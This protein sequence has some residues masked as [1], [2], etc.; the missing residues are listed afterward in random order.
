MA[1]ISLRALSA[2][3]RGNHAPVANASEREDGLGLGHRLVC[4]IRSDGAMESLPPGSLAL[5]S[6][7]TEMSSFQ[8]VSELSKIL[9]VD[10]AESREWACNATRCGMT[11]GRPVVRVALERDGSSERSG[12]PSAELPWPAAVAQMFFVRVSGVPQS[13]SPLNRNRNDATAAMISA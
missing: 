4:S 10:I 2:T 12:G 1:T 6:T 3:Q 11:A 8:N 9:R 13:P 5:S 7:P